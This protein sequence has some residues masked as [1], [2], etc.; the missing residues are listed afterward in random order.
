MFWGIKLLRLLA[1]L[2]EH[3]GLVPSIH[4]ESFNLL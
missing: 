1:T 3:H 2:T 4:M